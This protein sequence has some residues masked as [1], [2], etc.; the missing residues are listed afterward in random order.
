MEFI[1][2]K[3]QKKLLLTLFFIVLLFLIGISIYLIKSTDSDNYCSTSTNDAISDLDYKITG[4]PIVSDDIVLESISLDKKEFAY[5]NGYDFCF[6]GEVN[7]HN[8]LKINVYDINGVIGSGYLVNGS[9]TYCLGVDKDFNLNNNFVGL[10]CVNCDVNGNNFT[11][12]ISVGTD[13]LLLVNG[14]SLFGDQLDFSLKAYVDCDY[15]V[16]RLF[17][18][19]MLTIV[20]FGLIFLLMLGVSYIKK[21]AFD[22]W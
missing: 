14:V 11:P 8:S 7:A 13:V 6:S 3:L 10:E 9:G 20:L 1:D 5:Y 15:T 18:Y 17:K 22:G 21:V 4:S 16:F 12:T 2:D 19:M